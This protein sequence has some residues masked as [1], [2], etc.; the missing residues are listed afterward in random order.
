MA[1]VFPRGQAGVLICFN[2]QVTVSQGLFLAQLLVK[3]SGFM[4]EV[5]WQVQTFTL[6]AFKLIR[7]GYKAYQ[8]FINSML[9]ES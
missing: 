2:L 4:F 7:H 6:C 1:F 3:T 9:K 5:A 8:Y